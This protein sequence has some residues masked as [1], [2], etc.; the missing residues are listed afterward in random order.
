MTS[1]T[2]CYDVQVALKFIARGPEVREGRRACVLPCHRSTLHV[3]VQFL[4]LL[5]TACCTFL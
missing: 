2:P 3:R 4:R 1:P 5:S